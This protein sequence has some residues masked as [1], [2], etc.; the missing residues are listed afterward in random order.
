MKQNIFHKKCKI[1]LVQF[2]SKIRNQQLCDDCFF[3]K[4]CLNCNINIYVKYNCITLCKK[5]VS[6]NRKKRSK[7]YYVENKNLLSIKNK[8]YR[9]KYKNKLNAYNKSYYMCNQDNILKQ[10]K[11]YGVRKKEQIS[12]QKRKHRQNNKQKL[13]KKK[14]KYEAIKK[15]TDPSFKLRKLVSSS[16]RNLLKL[17]NYSKNGNSIIK[18]LQYSILDMKIH[19]ESLFELWMNWQN[20]GNYDSKTWN[21]NDQSTWTWQ[22]DHIIPQSL[23]PYASMEDDNF[24]RCWSLD[25]LRPY[26]AKQNCLDGANK[27]RHKVKENK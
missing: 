4:S 16:I 1:C 9:E 19:I 15:E 12:T 2:E 23:L 25:N 27:I 18:Y 11:E 14:N 10:K 5:C 22:L 20:H 13:N 6:N 17:N 24:K 26:G 7:I 21:D 8:V 3:T